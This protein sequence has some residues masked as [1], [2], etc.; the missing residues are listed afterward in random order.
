M[1]RPHEGEVAL[2]HGFGR[3]HRWLEAGGRCTLTTDVGTPFQ[4]CAART[5][6]GPHRGEDVIKFFQRGKEYARAYQCCW[7]H[8]YNCNRTRIGM[9]CRA[10]DR[11]VRHRGACAGA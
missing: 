3:T 7:G 4:A 11:E 10:L 9:Y 6:K 5:I 8:Y 2:T 1:S